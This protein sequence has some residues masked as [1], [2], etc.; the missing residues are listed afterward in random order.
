MT[1]PSSGLV[2]YVAQV[3]DMTAAQ[4]SAAN[5]TAFGTLSPATN[6][7]R[8]TYTACGVNSGAST[9][10][11]VPTQGVNANPSA[12]VS[13]AAPSGLLNLKSQISTQAALVYR[14]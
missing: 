2:G 9:S 14:M 10:L 7:V 3:I 11:A 1:F 5:V 13:V 4:A 6:D 12:M 8:N